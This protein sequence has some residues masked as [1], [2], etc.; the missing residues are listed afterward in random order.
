[1]TAYYV[2]VLKEIMTAFAHMRVFTSKFSAGYRL[3]VIKLYLLLLLS[4]FMVYEI[5]KIH[6]TN[7]DTRIGTISFWLVLSILTFGL[8]GLVCKSIDWFTEHP[9][10]YKRPYVHGILLFLPF[11]ASVASYMISFS[12]YFEKPIDFTLSIYIGLLT[13]AVQVFGILILPKNKPI[14]IQI[15]EK[16]ADL[17][18][19]KILEA[20]TTESN[21]RDVIFKRVLGNSYFTRDNKQI[22]IKKLT[23]KDLE[24]CLLIGE[25]RE[26]LLKRF[27]AKADGTEFMVYELEG[28]AGAKIAESLAGLLILLTFTTPFFA[29]YIERVLAYLG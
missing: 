25:K 17:S 4:I 10:V 16:P 6:M 1:M 3:P 15:A 21:Y 2:D 14:S 13:F 27:Y 9:R 23:A 7:R 12:K 28:L 11:A 8:G 20:L 24:E 22:E 29:N 19:E 5:I 26:L 18:D